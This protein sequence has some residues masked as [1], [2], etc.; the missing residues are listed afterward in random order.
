MLTA[1]SGLGHQEPSPETN[2]RDWEPG[3]LADHI[4]NRYH[5]YVWKTLVDLVFY[6]R[7]IASVHGAHHPELSEIAELTEKLNTE[8]HE[9]MK[10]E[11]EILFP[12]I[13]DVIRTDSDASRAIIRSVT[14]KL[15]EEHESAGGAMDTI[16]TLTGGYRVPADGCGTYHLTYKLLKQFEDDLHIHVHLENNIL[17]KKAQKL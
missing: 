12:A 3:R 16:N 1:L 17:F 11:E 9:H 4:V 10:T 13:K 6:T 7:K 2:F 14:G 8:L 5:R 15:G